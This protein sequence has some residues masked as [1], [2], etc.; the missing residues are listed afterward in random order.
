MIY[1]NFFEAFRA[2][3]PFSKQIINSNDVKFFVCCHL[4]IKVRNFVNQK[5]GKFSENCF[6]LNENISKLIEKS[7]NVNKLL[8]DRQN[9]MEVMSR[10]SFEIG[11]ERKEH[12]ITFSYKY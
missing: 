5:T 11:L 7:G 9:A 3:Q 4:G 8:E 12:P 6:S 1:H 10:G 2:I